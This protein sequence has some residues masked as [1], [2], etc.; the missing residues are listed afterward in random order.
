MGCIR[1]TRKVRAALSAAMK[2][3]T[4]SLGWKRPAESRQRIAES[5]K[6]N[7]NCVGRKATPDTLARMAAPFAKRRGIPVI[8]SPAPGMRGICPDYR[9]N[10]VV[11][12]RPEVQP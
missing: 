10:R 9:A 6:G 7:K 12:F 11:F 5:M 1:F 2:G 3:N 8:P 4:N